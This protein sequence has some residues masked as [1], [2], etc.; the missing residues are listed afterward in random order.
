[1]LLLALALGVGITVAIF[2]G[3]ERTRAVQ[4]NSLPVIELQPDQRLAKPAIRLAPR[5]SCA[6]REGCAR[7]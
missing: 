3:G 4:G 6:F 2:S 5:L 1:V 7:L